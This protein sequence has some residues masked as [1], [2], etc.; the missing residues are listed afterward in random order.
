M[1]WTVTTSPGDFG[2]TLYGIDGNIL[3]QIDPYHESAYGEVF[4]P[5]VIDRIIFDNGGSNDGIHLL[6]DITKNG[7]NL[8]NMYYCIDCES[9]STSIE[10]G[11][12]Y[13]DGDMD[14]PSDSSNVANCD[15]TCEFVARNTSLG[16]IHWKILILMFVIL[17]VV[18]ILLRLLNTQ[19]VF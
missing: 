1:S 11:H 9:D 15:T 7:Q 17:L 18:E 4:M 12:L 16:I 2:F 14:I 13:L 19:R 5:D 6:I 3:Q 8:N 10:L